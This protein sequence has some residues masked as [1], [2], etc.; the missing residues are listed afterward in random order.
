MKQPALFKTRGTQR[1]WTSGEIQKLRNNAH[2]GAQACATILG[3]SVKSVKQ[4][5]QRERISLRP[6]GERRGLLL[7]QAKHAAWM[8]QGVISP[9][10]LREMREQAIA[11]ELDL[12]RL[13]RIIVDR[14][15]NPHRPLCPWCGTRPAERQT[16]GLCE[17]CHLRELA[18]AHREEA[19][20]AA[21]RR[22]LDAARQQASRARRRAGDPDT[23]QDA[24]VIPLFGDTDQE[25]P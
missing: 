7:G 1:A 11:G 14:V 25:Q 22:E 10:R 12:G 19:E 23:G 5:A 16:T 3:R 18:R 21:A 24:D 6:P 2:L 8:D 15:R 20:R 9:G 13:E 17:P 4:K